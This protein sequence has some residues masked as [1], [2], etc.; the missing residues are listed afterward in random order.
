M[1]HNKELCYYKMYYLVCITFTSGNASSSL[2]LIFFFQKVSHLFLNSSHSVT[3]LW[4]V[5][6]FTEAVSLKDCTEAMCSEIAMG[7]FPNATGLQTK[8][9]VYCLAYYQE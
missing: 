7:M 6:L 4:L 3:A 5:D 1:K 8:W 2:I 9:H